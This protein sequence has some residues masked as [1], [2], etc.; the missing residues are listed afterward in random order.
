MDA[1]KGCS[2]LFYTFEPLQYQPTFDSARAKIP[3][4]SFIATFPPLTAA[5][6][7]YS[8]PES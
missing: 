7:S 2:G 8:L 5:G 3:A 1:L 4:S 6:N